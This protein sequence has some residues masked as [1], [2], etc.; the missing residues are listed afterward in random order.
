MSPPKMDSI[1]SPSKIS[2]QSTGNLE[3]VD[4]S[5]EK[6]LV[7]KVSSNSRRSISMAVVVQNLD[8]EKK[9]RAIKT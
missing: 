8:G 3:I 1:K 2:R 6:G 7:S 9:V 4:R 5:R